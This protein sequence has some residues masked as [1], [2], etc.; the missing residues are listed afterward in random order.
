MFIVTIENQDQKFVQHS[1][2]MDKR[3]QEVGMVRRI[4]K[5]NY[6]ECSKMGCQST[7]NSILD[8]Q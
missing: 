5:E 7:D 8:L 6:F 3:K 1:L 4:S 2:G